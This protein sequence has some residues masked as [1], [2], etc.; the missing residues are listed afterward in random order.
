MLDCCI[1]V[2][3]AAIALDIDELRRR[4]A[5]L[6]RFYAPL[7]ADPDEGS[8]LR[9]E[10]DLRLAY[11]QIRLAGGRSEEPSVLTWGERLPRSI[12]SPAR[13]IQ[14]PD[15]ELRHLDGSVAAFAVDQDRGRLVTGGGA[16]TALYVARGEQCTAWSSHAVAAAWIANGRV[17]LDAEMIP[18][19]LSLEFVSGDRSLIAGARAVAPGVRID[20]D[21]DGASTESFWP[22]RDRWAAIPPEDAYEHAEAAILRSLASRVDGAGPT[23]VGLTGGADSRV[24]AAALLELGVEYSTF[25]WAEPGW[26]DATGA[27]RVAEALEVPHAILAPDYLEGDGALA[28]ALANVR[29]TEGALPVASVRQSWPDS[30]R[31]FVSGTGAETGR[32]FYYA[33]RASANPDADTETVARAFRHEIGTR[34][35]GARRESRQAVGRQTESLVH[36]AAALGYR[37]WQCLDVVYAEQRVRRWARAYLPCLPIQLVPAFGTPEVMRALTCL[38]LSERLSNGFNRRFMRARNPDLVPAAPAEV[39]TASPSALQ[40]GAR[41]LGPIRARRAI[42][43]RRAERRPGEPWLLADR[44][45]E[46]PSLH[47]W[48]VEDA[49]AS[50]L[51]GDVMGS[52]WT[53]TVRDG[54]LAGE[55][56]PTTLALRAAAP[57]ALARALSELG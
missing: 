50:R 31:T 41:A 48:I 52:R 46:Q 12:S 15:T 11:G 13:L 28:D 26:P 17:E 14:A 3:H 29:W 8:E 53:S 38:P 9:H 40:R 56:R 25:T 24:V 32:A 55:E 30:M 45:P 4:Y 57:V 16:P 35:R 34:L 47:E 33:G 54:F 39:A 43:E 5:G 36:D 22:A 27:E 51:I 42:A 6:M 1:V 7:G 21:R 20:F 37:G 23:Y 49:L 10:S 44:W 2:V 18:E 19:L